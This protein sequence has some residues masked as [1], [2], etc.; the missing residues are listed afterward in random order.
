M[1]KSSSKG[2]NPRSRN[3]A[4]GLA[5]GGRGGR[6]CPHPRASRCPGL[7]PGVHFRREG[8][9]LDRDGPQNDSGGFS[10]IV[11]SSIYFCS[12]AMILARV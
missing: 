3:K 12:R 5:H 8:S 4:L 2:I 10:G 7:Y 11:V 6:I 9:S 1:P